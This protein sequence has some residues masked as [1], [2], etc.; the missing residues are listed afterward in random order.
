MLYD[1]NIS[2]FAK[3]SSSFKFNPS[4]TIGGSK[5]IPENSIIFHT[6]QWILTT[7]YTNEKIY[8]YER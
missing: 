1:I 6:N 3:F 8:I 4:K 7:Q 5:N 2:H